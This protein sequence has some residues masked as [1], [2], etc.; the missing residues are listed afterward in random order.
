MSEIVHSRFKLC[1]FCSNG[2]L[3]MFK[4]LVDTFQIF[5]LYN[6]IGLLVGAIVKREFWIY[7]VKLIRAHGG[8]LGVR[9][10]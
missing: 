9:R 7:V 10:R 1:W 8:C 4:S 6:G 5:F 3:A 2:R